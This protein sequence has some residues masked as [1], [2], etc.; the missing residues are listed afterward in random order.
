MPH[1][2]I[3]VNLVHAATIAKRLTSRIAQTV[4]PYRD[5]E[6]LEQAQYIFAEL[7]PYHLESIDPTAAEQMIVSAHVL[8]LA[9]HLVTLIEL[10]G[11]GND[12][13]GQSIRNLFECLGRGQ[14]GAI[15]GLKAGEHPDSLQRP[16]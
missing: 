15:L 8:D 10:E 11:C 1:F 3:P 7:F 4:P 14:E 5:S 16:I 2:E 6:S 9:R 13:I 12:R